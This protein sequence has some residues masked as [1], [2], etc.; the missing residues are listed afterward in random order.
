[1]NPYSDIEITK[2]ALENYK[3]DK[4]KFEKYQKRLIHLEKIKVNLSHPR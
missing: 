1:L 3:S 4:A 2:R